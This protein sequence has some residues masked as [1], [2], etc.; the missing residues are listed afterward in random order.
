VEAAVTPNRTDVLDEARRVITQDRQ[1]QYGEAEDSF[2]SI[3]QMWTAYKGVPFT[4]FDVSMMM[5]LLKVARASS[6][7]KHVDNLVDICGYAALAS[8]MVHDG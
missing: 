2:G 3:A 1:D 6:N 7:P 4:S 8:E 5:T